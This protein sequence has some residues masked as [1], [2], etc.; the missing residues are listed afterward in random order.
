[1]TT[2][3]AFIAWLFILVLSGC[4]TT[5]YTLYLQDVSI[6]GAISQPSVRVTDKNAERPL[7]ITPHIAFSTRSAP[8]LAG[9][10]DRHSPVDANGV[11]QVDAELDS[12]NNTVSYRERP[13]ANTYTF[14]GQ[15][16]SWKMPGGSFGVDID[17]SLTN[18]WALSLGTSY[19]PM[20]GEG[21]WGYRLGMGLFTERKSSALR[22][23]AGLQW[24]EMRYDAL[25]AI[26]SSPDNEVG[27][28]QDRG[29][30][31]QMDFYGAV[32]FN[33]THA[34]WFANIFLQVALSK[35]S[36]AK[37]K[38]SISAPGYAYP[39]YSPVVIVHDQ[40]AQFSSTFV[41]I[42]PGVF[43]EID[44]TMRLLGGVRF[45]MQTQIIESSPGSIVLPFLQVDWMI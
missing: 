32:T 39:F 37:F 9:Q 18:H 3:R 8:T 2:H 35:Q 16:L 7:R 14:T 19:S 38:P 42:T 36:L 20:N 25:T 17:Y 5:E 26:V 34:D 40:R 22:F 44:P 21:L 41:I 23:D 45:N 6:E 33:T 12:S 27:F 43:F 1:M 10:I 24:Q 15:N 30:G 11:Y 4:T 31:M 28:F 29:K 13:G